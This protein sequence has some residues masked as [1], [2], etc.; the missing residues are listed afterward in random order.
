MNIEFKFAAKEKIIVNNP[1]IVA[2]N[3]FGTVNLSYCV[4]PYFYEYLNKFNANYQ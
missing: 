4:R 2:N 3:Y 1:E